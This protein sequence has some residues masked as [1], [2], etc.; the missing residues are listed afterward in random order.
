[1][2]D[3]ALDLDNALWRFVLPFY[4][5]AG[6]SPACLV[7][8]DQ[9]GVDVNILLVAAYAAAARG[10][11][12]DRDDLAAADALVSGW[13]REVVEPLRRVRNRMKS[14]PAPAPSP[15]TE[16]LRNKI[17]AAELD[18][19]QIALAVLFAWLERRPARATQ[20]K[21]AAEAV[22]RHF[23]P[24]GAFPPDVTAALQTLS[25]AIAKAGKGS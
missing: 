8:Q 17:K 7:L 19:E 24:D 4:G 25:Q 2:A 13:R 18:G 14:G 9:I 12:L 3:A 5:S 6:V 16:P 11:V 15:A 1:M 23:H 20:E 10:I 21:N 22:A